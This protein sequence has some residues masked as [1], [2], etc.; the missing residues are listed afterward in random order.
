MILMAPKNNT[1]T[2]RIFTAVAVL[3][4][5]AFYD[6]SGIQCEVGFVRISC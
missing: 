2:D 3:F 6:W 1:V 5:G 4:T